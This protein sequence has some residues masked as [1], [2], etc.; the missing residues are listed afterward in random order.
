MVNAY[1]YF[2]YNAATMNYAVF[3]PNAAAYDP[4]TKINCTSMFDAQMDAIY[5]AM[6]RPGYG[7]G[8]EIAVGEARW[9]GRSGWGWRRPGISMPG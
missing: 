8:V 6:K 4:A 3:C 5:M 1:P 7:D 2:S 9:P